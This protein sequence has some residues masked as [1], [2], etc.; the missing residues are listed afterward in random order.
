MRFVVHLR[1]YAEFGRRLDE[2]A[3]LALR[4]ERP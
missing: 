2:P 4:I 3:E 1:Y